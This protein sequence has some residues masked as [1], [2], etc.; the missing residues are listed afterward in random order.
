MKKIKVRI[1][2][3]PKMGMG[4]YLPMYQN[5]TSDTIPTL[6][7]PGY[8]SQAK[9]VA[10]TK[11]DT[12]RVVAPTPAP[13][14]SIPRIDSLAVDSLVG[15]FAHDTLVTKTPSGKIK[16]EPKI[17]EPVNKGFEP[18]WGTY[19]ALGAGAL[20]GA[21]R[22]GQ[23]SRPAAVKP[24]K[25]SLN[26]DA[27]ITPYNG[28][29][30]QLA[31]PSKEMKAHELIKT[32]YKRAAYTKQELSTL[33]N[34]GVTD[35]SIARVVANIKN[36]T[37]PAEKVAEAV[38]ESEGIWN[39]IRS[40]YGALRA[41]PWFKALRKQEGGDPDSMLENIGEFL[42]PTGI[43]SY[44]DV[45]RSFQDPHASWWE[46]GLT[47]TSALPIVGKLGKGA[48]AFSEL[49]K[50]GKAAHVAGKVMTPVAQMDR[51]INPASRLVSAATAKGLQNAPKAVK[52]AAQFGSVSNQANRF[53]IGADMLMGYPGLDY[54]GEMEEMAYGGQKGWGLDLNTRRNYAQ[55]TQGPTDSVAR[56][57][58]PV[59]PEDATYEAEHGE[60]IVGDM[61]KDGQDE[62][63]TFGGK[64]HSQGGTPSNAEGFIFSDTKKMSLKGPIVEEFGKTAGKK[65]TPAQIAKQYDLTKYKAIL[66]DT[67]S[68]ELQ[69]RTA[70][71]M[72]NNYQKKLGKLALVQ[73]SMKGFPKG[74]PDFAAEAHPQLVE[75]LKQ[76]QQPQME[77]SE[78]Q[79]RWGGYP[80]MQDAG[81]TPTKKKLPG[82]Y[83]F[84]TKANTPSGATSRT[85]QTT[86][87]TP[88]S[89]SMYD[90]YDYW[91]SQ[92]GREF[93]DAKD[94][95]RYVF[96][97]LIKDDPASVKALTNKF[98]YP[99]AHTLADGIL[100]ARSAQ[101]LKMRLKNKK[102]D[103]GTGTLAT[104]TGTLA[105]KTD[106]KKDAPVPYDY[107]FGEDPN[108]VAPSKGR[109]PYN[110]FDVANI[111]GAISTPVNMYGPR[112]YLPNLEQVRGV[113][114]QP[115]YN[116]YLSAAN[117]RAQM[118]NTFGNAGA[119]MAANTYNHELLQGIIQE[120]ARS[121]GSNLQVANQIAAQNNQIINQGEMLRAQAMSDNYDKWVKTQE[122]YDIAN[123]LKWRKDVMPAIQH[124]ERQRALMERFNA[125]NP[126]YDVVG[127]DWHIDY[128]KGKGRKDKTGTP[129][130][131][132][133]QHF[134]AENPEAQQ[135]YERSDDAGKREIMK[136]YQLRA[137]EHRAMF[138][139]NPKNYQGNY[140][141]PAAMAGLGLTG[142]IGP[143]ADYGDY[144]PYSN[145]Y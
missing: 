22:L 123:K 87:Y 59:S 91:S 49:S 140:M 19:G 72:L 130:A 138:S 122:E 109:L 56:T 145:F 106:D 2:K 143:G 21:Y 129:G 132:T 89:G 137:R 44:D 53:F 107:N 38:K 9:P 76:G 74:I 105:T 80:H 69:H 93:T 65:Y 117:T 13:Y 35:A 43:S 17:P 92:A 32:M 63:L 34:M 12:I 5:G 20:Y 73:E 142:P 100:G 39:T 95:Q 112:M 120:S 131:Y 113:Y 1:K 135:M 41:M 77:E 33:K 121:R 54:G 47:A 6:E 98:G 101:A 25:F 78:E 68:D 28:P 97:E 11:K 8:F 84:F 134:F 27:I 3:Y 141:N 64:R 66:D 116:P 14:D 7:E 48:K 45:Y 67:Q 4:G 139:K 104:K 23:G 102:P 82:W 118:N 86:T 24:G 46:K 70:S 52:S 15:P 125:E 29:G 10:T 75:K 85:G 111:A 94:L 90:D 124:A 115:D 55:P 30:S 119:A 40:G 126:Q 96:G 81:A 36:G 133:M 18:S 61:D 110:R 103:T 127:S 88:D 99:S 71:L 26:P 42:D 37:I 108:F 57:L 58:G 16:K 83:N 144:D 60:V 136:M 31:L 79:M 50:L 51:Y 62:M 128:T 114:D